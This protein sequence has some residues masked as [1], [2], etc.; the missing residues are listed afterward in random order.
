MKKR[1]SSVDSDDRAVY[2]LD[3]GHGVGASNAIDDLVLLHEDHRRNSGHGKLLAQF[4]YSF[5]VDLI[6]KNK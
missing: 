5:R 6:K 3:D 2:L 4:R 1:E